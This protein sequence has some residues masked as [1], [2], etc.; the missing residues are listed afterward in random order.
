MFFVSIN[1][2]KNRIKDLFVFDVNFV[3]TIWHV[4]VKSMQH[5]IHEHY[6]FCFIN[7]GILVNL[8]M[9][10]LILQILKLMII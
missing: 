2:N 4:N 8:R 7:I 10:Q 3:E 5:D 1:S 9:S 6:N